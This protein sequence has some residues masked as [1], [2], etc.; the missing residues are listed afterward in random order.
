MGGG[1][2]GRGTLSIWVKN[3]WDV[4]GASTQSPVCVFSAT[5]NLFIYIDL[6]W[7]KNKVVVA[8]E[9]KDQKLSDPTWSWGM[10]TAAGWA[11]RL[12]ARTYRSRHRLPFHSSSV[13]TSSQRSPT[14]RW[15]AAMCQKKSELIR[16]QQRDPEMLR[17]KAS[18]LVLPSP[19]DVGWAE[20]AI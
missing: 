18:I 10:V 3:W 12:R 9:K 14:V 4:S 7:Q 8:W 5:L 13:L 2:G 6:Y 19:E 1:V 11:Q 20:S 17:S 15:A 16:N